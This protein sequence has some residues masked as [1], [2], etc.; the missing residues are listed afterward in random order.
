MIIRTTRAGV[1][2]CSLPEAPR[3]A[4]RRWNASRQEARTPR[5]ALELGATGVSRV[6]AESGRGLGVAS[7]EA[8][9]S[10]GPA[11][12]QAGAR[13]RGGKGEGV[14]GDLVVGYLFLGG[15][16]AGGCL[17]CAL[18][19]L[20]ADTSA[21][22]PALAA[23]LRTG[24]GRRWSRLFAPALTVSA[25]CL[26]VGIACLAADLGR[27]DR[28]LLLMVSPTPSYISL[29]AWA[30]VACLGLAALLAAVWRGALAVRP[31]ALATL[32]A[33]TALAALTTA[34]YTGLLLA[35]MPAVPLWC[36][37]WLPALFT[38]SAAS[39]GIA[40]VMATTHLTGASADFGVVLARLALA[41]GALIALEAV[42]VAAAI[43][44][45]WLA[46]GGSL[47]DLAAAISAGAAALAPAVATPASAADPSSLDALAAA[48]AA[49]A[50]LTDA[51]ARAS[52]AALV[53]GPG[54]WLF[55][56][57]FV[58]AGLVIPL[59]LDLVL[60]A[61]AGS[62][63][64]RAALHARDTGLDPALGLPAIRGP[65]PPRA[66]RAPSHRAPAPPLSAS[67]RALAALA[68]AGCVL[69]GGL[70]IRLLVVGAG[71]QPTIGVIL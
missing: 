15:T 25:A 51:A 43:V 24:E 6:P 35:S 61:D 12:R 55:W 23:R 3:D 39:C 18:M 17:V 59:G 58:L 54:A 26:A 57:G 40:L 37:P 48:P 27:P 45:V 66:G 19:G 1:A 4:A 11:T 60:Y 41:D 63:A 67:V 65:R 50:T 7:A 13:A 49:A 2:R 9:R 32:E 31:G 52:V 42:A 69:V 38:L 33:L 20:L 64:R 16:G 28:L 29:G 70:L 53:A 56:G 5:N 10:R 14:F 36:T 44:A 30:L 21:L 62:R 68:A 71:L 34:A 8:G 47:A 22:A 46:A